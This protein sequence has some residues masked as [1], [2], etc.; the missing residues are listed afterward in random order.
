MYFNLRDKFIKRKQNKK[1]QSE[2]NKILE[3]KVIGKRNNLRI[4][5]L[6]DH[7][8]FSYRGL[9]ACPDEFHK[10]R[11]QHDDSDDEHDEILHETVVKKGFL[12]VSFKNE[13]NGIDQFGKEKTCCNK[14]PDE[15]EPAQIGDITRKIFDSGEKIRVELSEKFIR[16]NVEALKC[17]LRIGQDSGGDKSK[18]R[19]QRNRAE[20]CKVGN[21]NGKVSASVLV[22]P[23]EYGS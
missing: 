7:G 11:D 19:N 9:H 5:V 20:E 4:Y 16:E 6:C 14:R 1:S 21:G 15:P 8:A 18:E 17:C 13:V 12:V 23:F 10:E 22:E 2:R 3:K